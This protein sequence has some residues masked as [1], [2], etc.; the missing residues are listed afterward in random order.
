MM[1]IIEAQHGFEKLEIPNYDAELLDDPMLIRCTMSEG[2]F[3]GEWIEI[4]EIRFLD[5]I[6]ED[7]TSEL[8]FQFNSSKG[9]NDEGLRLLSEKIIQYML[10]DLMNRQE[11][12]EM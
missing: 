10:I 11:Y 5:E 9:S 3:I 6:N 4:G 1:K 7:G 8:A 12:A 2:D